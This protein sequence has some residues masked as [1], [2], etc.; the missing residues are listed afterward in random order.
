MHASP[1]VEVRSSREDRAAFLLQDYAQLF[2][3]PGSLKA[4]LQ[5]MVGLHSRERV[6]GWQALVDQGARVELARELIDRHYDPAYA[7]SC[8][9]HFAQLPQALRLDFRP[10]DV[11]VVEQARVLLAR[12]ESMDA[13]A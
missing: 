3:D 12:L 11:D 5:R 13:G 4:Q 10:N 2:D 8:H 9:A 6:V 1:C 7:R